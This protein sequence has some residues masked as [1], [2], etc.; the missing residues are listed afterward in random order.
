VVSVCH[1]CCSWQQI[2]CTPNS[3]CQ[4]NKHTAHGCRCSVQVLQV[5]LLYLQCNVTAISA[6]PN[7]PHS[8]NTAAKLGHHL[9]QDAELW[10]CSD[11]LPSPQ[12]MLFHS[13]SQRYFLGCIPHSI[14]PAGRC[15]SVS[16]AQNCAARCTIG[17]NCLVTTQKHSA[18]AT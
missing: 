13:C 18:N 7:N 4:R 6:A 10:I 5:L 16:S 3:L 8:T 11:P 1:P 9:Q 15:Q 12:P 14:L 17:N 2:S